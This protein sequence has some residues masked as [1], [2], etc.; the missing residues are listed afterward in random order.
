MSKEEKKPVQVDDDEPDDWRPGTREYSAP[1]AQHLTETSRATEDERLLLREERLESMQQRG[2]RDASQP[3]EAGLYT[4]IYIL[5][6][7]EAFRECWKRH[8]NNERTETR[9]N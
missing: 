9:D 3:V 2:R 6:P 7:M 5:V 4:Y 8:G 1:A